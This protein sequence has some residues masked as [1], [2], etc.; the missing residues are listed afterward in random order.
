MRV[1]LPFRSFLPSAEDRLFAFVY[2]SVVEIRL[3]IRYDKI[4]V[5][6]P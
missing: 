1:R 2:K 5:K 4:D 6:G 3:Q